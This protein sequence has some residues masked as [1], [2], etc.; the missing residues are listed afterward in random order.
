MTHRLAVILF[1]VGVLLLGS[2]DAV[3]Q[4]KKKTAT[5]PAATQT[6][7]TPP[8]TPAKS[9]GM[10]RD[11]LAKYKGQLTTLGTLKQV[12]GDFFSVIDDEIETLYPLSAIR[13]IKVLKI[14]ASDDPDDEPQPKLAI[15]LH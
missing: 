2:P 5:P 3:A 12:E 10:L 14:E 11:F 13:E 6:K 1:A 7:E 9:W 8:P 4:Q 15:R